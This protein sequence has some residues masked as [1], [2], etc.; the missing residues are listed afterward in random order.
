MTQPTRNLTLYA[1]PRSWGL[2][3][4]SPYCMKLETYLRSRDLA[5]ERAIGDLRKAP[6]GQMPYASI[7][8]EVIGDSDA[9]IDRIEAMTGVSLD[10]ACSPRDL[11]RQRSFARMLEESTVWALRYAR[12]VDEGYADLSQFMHAILPAGLRVVLRPM[13]R[14]DMQKALLAQG[15]GRY[16]R[17]QIY[18]FAER[19]IDALAAELGERAF[20][21]GDTPSR[22]DCTAFGFVA[23]FLCEHARSPLTDHTAT[24]ANLVRHTERMRERCFPEMPSWVGR[25]V[26]GPIDEAGRQAA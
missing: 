17:E 6:R 22:L 3:N 8:G 19:Y 26:G 15:L 25:R 12:F 1:F 13:I 20:F 14:R 21:G 2:P 16:T 18:A 23:N 11:A 9:I 10:S 24:K 4:M 7:D 5:Y